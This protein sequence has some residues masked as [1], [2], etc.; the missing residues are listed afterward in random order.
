VA[1]PALG[2]LLVATIVAIVVSTADSYLLAPASS[3]ARD[4]YQRFARPDASEAE[5]V[6]AGRV[7]VVLLG[8]IAFGLAF[9]SEEFFSVARFAYTIYGVGVTPALLAALFLPRA[10]RGGAVA[11]M[12]LAVA[13]ALAWRAFGLEGRT[14][15]HP[16]IP[17]FAVSAATLLATLKRRVFEE[18]GG[19]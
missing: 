8:A 7:F 1:P 4:V 6:R 17:G 5:L 9:L 12:G 14:T 10:S 13:T 18:R 3:L 16:V 15:L 19:G 2:A 11:A